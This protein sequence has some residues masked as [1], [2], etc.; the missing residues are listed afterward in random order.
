MK[1]SLE[2]ERRS[3]LEQIEA[4]RAVYRRM[5]S[6]EPGTSAGADKLGGRPANRPPA[7]RSQAVQWMM[8]HPLWVAGGV[9]LLVLIA[10]RMIRSSTGKLRQRRAQQRRAQQR[11]AQQQRRDEASSGT[12]RALMTTAVLL[13]RDPA[14]L[15]MAVR[16]TQSAWQWLQRRRQASQNRPA[17]HGTPYQGDQPAGRTARPLASPDAQAGYRTH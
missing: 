5:L 2:D 1:P 11:Q 16:F 17:L 14:R 13:L 8:E 9:A 10:P 12:M 15:R 3:L 4:S 6:G 7:G